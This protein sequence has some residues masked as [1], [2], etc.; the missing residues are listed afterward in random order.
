MTDARNLD[1]QAVINC[2]RKALATVLDVQLLIKHS[3]KA[4]DCLETLSKAIQLTVNQDP[5]LTSTANKVDK[6]SEIINRLADQ[7][8]LLETRL[9]L[10]E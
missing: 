9:N 3:V 6:A 8:G 2:Q 5:V 10:L 7:V 1:R 4:S